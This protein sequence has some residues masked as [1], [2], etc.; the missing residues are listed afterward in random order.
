M[1][2]EDKLL[3]NLKWMTAELRRSMRRSKRCRRR[4]ASRSRS[5]DGL[6]LPGRGQPPEAALGAGRRRRD[7]IARFPHRPRAGTS[8][9]STTPTRTHTGNELRPTRV[10]SCRR[11]RLRR[12]LLRH[13]APRGA[14][15]G[16][17]AAAAAGDRRGRRSS[18]RHRPGVAA[19]QPAPACSPASCDHDY[20]RRTAT[21]APSELEGY[22]A[23]RQ[24]RP[25]WSPAASPTRSAWRARPSPSTPPARPRWSRCTWPRRRC[26]R[27]ECS[28][29]LAGGVTVMATPDAFVEFSRQR[30]LAAGRPL[31]AVRRRAPTAPAGPRA[32]GVLVLERLSDARRHG[33][34]VLPW[35]A[36]R[37][38]NQDGASNGLTAPNGPSQQ[39][40]IRAGARRR[41]AAGRPTSTWSRRTAPAPRSATRSRRRRCWRRTARTGRRTGRC[42]SARSSRTSATPRPR[43]GSPA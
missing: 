5:S 4:P 21:G 20:G 14:G 1:A 11:G 13:L 32:S 10:A 16:P 28:L 34:P 18:G 6:P 19:R 9:A 41:R 15:H 38:V 40:V 39:R 22:L 7:A 35:S 26:A 3:E 42:G 23:D 25:A 17:A 27:G 43:P 30:G 24:P 12:R 31:Q 33:H 2:N 8:T 29:A 37:A 36:A